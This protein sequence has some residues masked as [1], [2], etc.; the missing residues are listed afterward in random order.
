[1]PSIDE[2]E[3]IYYCFRKAQA[4][5]NNRGFRMPNDFEKFFYSKFGKPNREALNKI[6]GRFLTMWQNIDP[7]KYFLCGFEMKGQLQDTDL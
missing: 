4:D 3:N 5:F 2:I 1:M 7:E 6:T